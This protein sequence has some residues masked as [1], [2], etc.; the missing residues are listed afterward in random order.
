MNR[1]AFALA[2][3]RERRFIV[4]VLRR[5]RVPE[6]DAEDIA[7]DVVLAVLRSAA[8]GQLAKLRDLRPYVFA[9]A[10]RRAAGWHNARAREVLADDLGHV[11]SGAPSAEAV[12]V[13]RAALA[14]VLRKLTQ[15]ETAVLLAVAEGREAH[16]AAHVLGIPLGT[17]HSRLRRARR[18][19]RK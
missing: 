14:H 5:F 3:W 1:D 4:N 15:A 6:R 8:R 13:A 2:V 12:M 9:V 16:E 18:R 17:V 7:I 10:R 11:P 19:F